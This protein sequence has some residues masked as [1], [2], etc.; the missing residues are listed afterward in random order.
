MTTRTRRKPVLD[1][2]TTQRAGLMAEIRAKRAR[3]VHVRTDAEYRRDWRGV[4]EANL[5]IE[6]LNSRIVGLAP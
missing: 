3:L 4:R 1:E 5:A 6:R 2:P